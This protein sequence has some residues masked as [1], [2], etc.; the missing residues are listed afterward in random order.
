M[1]NTIVLTYEQA[2]FLLC[3]VT[4]LDTSHPAYNS[5]AYRKSQKQMTE[6]L[7]NVCW[8]FHEQEMHEKNMALGYIKANIKKWPD[9]LK[10]LQETEGKP[11]AQVLEEEVPKLLKEKKVRVKKAIQHHKKWMKKME[12]TQKSL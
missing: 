3:A 5:P 10:K 2:Q 9:L 8:A 11:I 1:N 6:M 4:D 7:S 12:K